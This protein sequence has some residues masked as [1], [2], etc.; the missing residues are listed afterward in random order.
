M[1]STK[2]STHAVEI[3]CIDERDARLFFDSQFLG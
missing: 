3:M 2:F 1:I